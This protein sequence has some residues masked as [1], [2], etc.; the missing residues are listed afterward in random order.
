[1]DQIMLQTS[2]LDPVDHE[3]ATHKV[4]HDSEED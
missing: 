2:D 4:L 1:M 3:L